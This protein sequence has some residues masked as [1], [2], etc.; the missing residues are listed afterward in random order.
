MI[1]KLL[2]GLEFVLHLDT[3]FIVLELQFY[4]A[5]GAIILNVGK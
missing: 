1:K 2:H 3:K 5:F 4:I